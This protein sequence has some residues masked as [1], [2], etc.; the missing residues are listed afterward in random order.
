MCLRAAAWK[1]KAAP[2]MSVAVPL[3]VML[4]MPPLPH[5]VGERN[6][7]RRKSQ[8]S[9]TVGQEGAA[10]TLRF[11]SPGQGERWHAKHDGE[12]VLAT[13]A[14]KGAE[15]VQEDRG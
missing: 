11:L 6:R 10:W 13:R 7:L 2:V 5:C 12:G 9:R 8:R 1:C 14:T 4:R 3:T 15:I